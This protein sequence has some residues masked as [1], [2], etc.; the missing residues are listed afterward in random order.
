MKFEWFIASRYFRSGRKGS[1]FLSFIKIMAVGGVAVGAAGL[2]ITL[3]IV[4]GFKSTIQEKI[5][6][7]GN[8]IVVSTYTGNPINRADTLLTFIKGKDGVDTAQLAIMGQGMVQ[9]RD[10]VDG[11]LIKGVDE[12]G[13]LSDLRNY[14]SAGVYDLSRQE[15][16][17]PGIV[18]G[19]RLARTLSASPGSTITVY[20]IR[21]TPSADEFPEIMQF[22]L[23]GVYQTGIDMF[24][25]TLVLIAYEHAVRLFDM[26]PR[27]ADQIDIRVA[28]LDDIREVHNRIQAE[29]SFPLYAE[30]IYQ[31]YSNLFAWINLQEQQIPFIIGVM[32][33][34][35]AFNLIGAVLM[36]VLERTRD[37]GIL[38]TMGATDKGIRAIFLYEGLLVGFLG[39][40]IGTAISLAFYW[41][42]TTW[43]IIP[44]PE[45][46]YYMSTAPVE[47]HL[48]D[49]VIVFGVTM[50]LCAIASF[51]PAYTAA[52]TDPLKVIQFGR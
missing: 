28:N 35:A 18:M 38:K 1:S 24:D 13:D 19:E 31:T 2:L 45:E 44:L 47:P 52:K 5:L 23:T 26:P 29:L 4:H 15:N 7:F 49:F 40:L 16:G 8:H 3:A 17:R 32:I 39:L 12:A 36:M 50:L 51:F 42:Q 21:G 46:N 14:I 34:V 30:N 9:S 6:G 11:T 20:T 10:F 22:T 27:V 37:I 41:V 48:L 33:I 25:D 43:G